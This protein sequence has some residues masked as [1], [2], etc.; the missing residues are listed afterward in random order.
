M[1]SHTATNRSLQN[2]FNASLLS[3]SFVFLRNSRQIIIIILMGM[4]SASVGG[5]QKRCALQWKFVVAGLGLRNCLLRNVDF[6]SG[7][8]WIQTQTQTSVFGHKQ[9]ALILIFLFLFS[10]LQILLLLASVLCLIIDIHFSFLISINS[11]KAFISIAFY[12]PLKRFGSWFYNSIPLFFIFF[13]DDW[14]NFC[15]IIDF[16]TFVFYDFQLKNCCVRRGE[17]N[18]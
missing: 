7:S 5:G 18:L 15:L 12:G 3:S 9:L 4:A 13:Q 17:T 14:I 2:P 10:N 1:I 6:R 16:L 8:T 11:L